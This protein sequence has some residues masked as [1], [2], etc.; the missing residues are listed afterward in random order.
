MLNQNELSVNMPARLK[1]PSLWFWLGSL[2]FLIFFLQ[3]IVAAGITSDRV[4]QGIFNLGS[5]FARAFPPDIERFGSIVQAMLETINIVVVGTSFGILFSFPLA[6]LAS[7]NTS[8]HPIIRNATRTLIALFRTVPDL[9]WALIFIIAVGLG[10]FAGILAIIVDVMG[11]C[12]RFF[13]ERVEELKPGPI[14]A[15]RAT[16][17]SRVSVILG[18]VIPAAFPSFVGSS[19]FAVEKSIRSAVVLGLV[20]AGGIGVEL[21]TSMTLFKYDEAL[22]IILIILA[23]VIGVEQASSRIRKKFI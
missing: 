18:S 2:V 1:K 22:T 8:P 19:L 23:F 3:G 12:G 6:L 17:A 7:N 16:G 10:P 21:N 5:F 11:F 14:E 9:V 13:S 4:M 15:L 20:G